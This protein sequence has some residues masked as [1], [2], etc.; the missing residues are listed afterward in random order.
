M[1]RSQRVSD[2]L[3]CLCRAYVSI[4]GG[5]FFGLQPPILLNLNQASSLDEA[6]GLPEEFAFRPLRPDK[7]YII[8]MSTTP[9]KCPACGAELDRR[10]ATET[11]SARRV[12]ELEAQVQIL[13]EKATS[14]GTWK[15]V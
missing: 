15:L 12:K 4:A 5:P 10:N 1:Q 7:S 14:A 6:I 2:K 8:H 13:N 9:T 11:D 3:T